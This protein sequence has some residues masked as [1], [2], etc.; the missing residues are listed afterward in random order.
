[1]ASGPLDQFLIGGGTR[2]D[3]ADQKAGPNE[4]IWCHFRRHWPWSGLM[5]LG[6]STIS[7]NRDS[8]LFV[9]NMGEWCVG[10]NLG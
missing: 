4:A 10:N 3:R 2:I 8:G 7:H 5:G 1:M 6:R 9:A